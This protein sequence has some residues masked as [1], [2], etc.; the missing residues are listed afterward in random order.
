M[1]YILE[2]LK[3]SE[4]K[5][6]QDSV[7]DLLTVHDNELPKSIR[8]AWW[9]YALTG[10]LLV[11][12]GAALPWLYIKYSG[13]GAEGV[14][15]APAMNDLAEYSTRKP[16]QKQTSAQTKMV[17]QSRQKKTARKEDDVFMKGMQTSSKQATLKESDLPALIQHDLPKLEISAHVYDPDP[18][19][20]IISIHGNVV[21]EGENVSAGV[22][23]ENI[24]PD[25]VILSFKGHRFY[26]PLF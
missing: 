17:Q 20:R 21:H 26:R 12:V 3:K 7:P 25:G 24:T 5:R 14:R 2:A 9:P 19:A 13:P 10:I 15:S 6:R 1:S 16:V 8:R 18:A 11:S 23:L 4:Q 22:R